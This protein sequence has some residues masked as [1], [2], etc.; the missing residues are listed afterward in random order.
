[1]PVTDV[2]QG[3]WLPPRVATLLVAASD[4]LDR[5]R[6]QADYI[7]DGVA[8]QVEINAALNALPASGGRVMLSE[9]TFVIADPI[10][11]PANSIWLRGQGRSTLINGNALT[12]GNHAIELTGRTGCAIKKLAIQTEAGGGKT[13][14]CIFADDGCNNLTIH[15]ITIVD[16][17]SD[18]VHIEGTNVIDI[19]I[20][21]L[22]VNDIDDHGIYVNMVGANY[23]DRL[24]VDGALILGAGIHG[25]RLG[26]CQYS[27]VS[28]CAVA[29]STQSGIVLDGCSYCDIS[30]C[31]SVLNTQYGVLMAGATHCLAEGC[32][33][34]LNVRH[35]IYLDDADECIVS[36]CVC[37][38]NDS[39]NTNTYDGIYV[40]SD[41]TDNN[42]TNNHCCAND[43][44]G[45]GIEGVRT[46][47]QGNFV[48]ENGY[49]GI[50]VTAAECK[51]SGNYCVDNSQETAETYH[52]IN[53]TAGADRCLVEDNFLYSGPD[54]DR[55]EDGISLMAGAQYCAII[56]NYC[57][58]CRGD[59]IKLQGTNP[60]TLIKGN[61][62]F[63]GYENGIV[64]TDSA[65][66]NI[67]GNL[68]QLNVHHG[69]YLDNADRANVTGN[70]CTENDAL[71]AATYDGIFVDAD[72]TQ[73]NVGHNYCYT[74]HRYGISILGG[75]LHS[76][77]GNT[78]ID[79]D[80]H[81]I[82]VA[83]SDC[84]INDNLCRGNG[85][86]SAGTY[87]AIYLTGDADRCQVNDN[88]CIDDGDTTE[89]GICLADGATG[90]Q[91]CGNYI[92]NLMGSGIMLTAN[93]DNCLI[94]DN[95]CSTCDDYGIKIAAATCDK[96]LVKGNQLLSNVTGAILDSGTLTTV[97]DDNEGIIITDIKMYRL[98]KNTSVAQ[99]VAGDVVSLKAVVA[100]DEVDVPTAAGEDQ[101]YGMI[102][103]TIAINAYGYVQVKGKTTV[104]KSTNGAGN[105]VIGDFLVTEAA[106]IR[107]QLYVAGNQAFARALA[108]CAAADC[109]ID[110]YIK[111]PWDQE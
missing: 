41:S 51:I 10:I 25:I 90:C 94:S 53:L 15:D 63:R 85:V 84:K 104:L 79:N 72:C 26:D 102:A 111:S 65:D 32:N 93:N 47:V 2:P 92:Y 34:S 70:T 22:R 81:G 18:G 74:N 7:C 43:R 89:D 67:I 86:D 1:M 66:C 6:A 91:I 82:Y 5:T 59:G 87:H 96:N 100:G 58:Y 37:S 76:V 45:L 97:E 95:F 12:T 75:S 56:G 107:A 98:V 49:H 20:R 60:N 68:C 69:I 108:A 109:T 40:D 101:V 16:G 11:L 14:H 42:I 83:G 64:I 54:N 61:Y 29:V 9:G 103:E 3:L 48:Y 38:G 73:C 105:I 39:G 62:C 35:G 31:I 80:Q 46:N 50:H 24:M 106:G 71:N 36:G 8:D 77:I 78:V 13:C 30:N 57:Y 110:A 99:R 17:D 23:C 28:N 27:E 52:G 88:T 21:G 55:Q 33:T 19:H 4:A 44:Y